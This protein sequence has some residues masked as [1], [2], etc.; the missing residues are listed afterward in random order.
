MKKTLTS[1]NKVQPL[2]RFVTK[3]IPTI[4][5]RICK[6]C[7]RDAELHNCLV[8]RLILAGHMV[9]ICIPEY[10]EASQVT[11]QYRDIVCI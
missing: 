4:G 7:R 6:T 9:V 10:Q 11:G 3:D 2:Q 1:Y 5:T 8:T